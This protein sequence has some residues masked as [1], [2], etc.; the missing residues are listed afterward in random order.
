MRRTLVFVMLLAAAGLAQAAEF[1]LPPGKWWEDQRVVDK[2]GLSQEQQTAIH[3]LVYDHARRMID[4]NAG[5]R[6]AELEL[7]DAA[8]R[9]R[10]DEQRIRAAF[11][12]F[13]DARRALETERFEMLLGVRKVLSSEQWLA[14]QDLRDQHKRLQE[15]R[16]RRDPRRP[17]GPQPPGPGGR[18]P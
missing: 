18:R 12:A 2:V 17:L 9:A 16:E 3:R 4:L 14:L 7:A 10:L 15:L 1:D 11:E 8:D 6:K 13:Q 5:L